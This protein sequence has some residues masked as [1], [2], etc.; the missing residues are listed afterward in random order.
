MPEIS[1]VME[2]PLSRSK[3]TPVSPELHAQSCIST[4]EV[5][6]LW[7]NDEICSAGKGV[8]ETVERL[9]EQEVG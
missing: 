7:H 5:Q 2:M 6:E 1:V 4:D 8:A 3:P 9:G